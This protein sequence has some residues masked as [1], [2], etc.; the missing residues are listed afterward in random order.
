MGSKGRGGAETVVVPVGSF[1]RSVVPTAILVMVVKNAGGEGSDPRQVICAQGGVI[2]VSGNED[3][4]LRLVI[5]AVGNGDGELVI[6]SCKRVCHNSHLA[7]GA[8]G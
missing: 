6:T 5:V 1:A 4:G 2:V 8:A 3:G 7:V